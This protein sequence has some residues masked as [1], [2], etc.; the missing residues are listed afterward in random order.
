MTSF[1]Q[2][3]IYLKGNPE[4]EVY[5]VLNPTLTNGREV[6]Y[7]SHPPHSVVRIKSKSTKYM[8]LFIMSLTHN[9]GFLDELFNVSSIKSTPKL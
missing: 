4:V 6:I 2:I 5:N 9:Q 1:Y 8:P 3:N 7:R